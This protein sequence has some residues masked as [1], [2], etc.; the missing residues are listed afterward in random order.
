MLND[1][2]VATGAPEPP[3]GSVAAAEQAA[4][5]AAAH[6]AEWSHDMTVETHVYVPAAV[7]EGWMGVALRFV[8]QD[9]VIV[10]A[11]QLAP[12]PRVAVGEWRDGEQTLSVRN[13][14]MA[15]RTAVAADT[16]FQLRASAIGNEVRVHL[17]GD[18]VLVTAVAAA[19]SASSS[20]AGLYTNEA[21]YARFRGTDVFRGS[22]DVAAP[23]VQELQVAVLDTLADCLSCDSF[24]Y[25]A[26]ATPQVFSVSPPSGSAGTLVTVTGSSLLHPLPSLHVWIGDVECAVQGVSATEVTCTAGANVVGA[27]PVRVL[28]DGVGPAVVHAHHTS[29]SWHA[30]APEGSTHSV[31]TAP[32]YN[33][34]FTHTLTAVAAPTPLPAGSPMG[35]SLLTLTGEGF[36]SQPESNL[37]TVCGRRCHVSEAS[38]TQLTCRVPPLVDNLPTLASGT[39]EGR[40][41]VTALADGDFGTTIE[42]G[43]WVDGYGAELII[44]NEALVGMQWRGLHIP[45]GATILSAE[46]VLT[47]AQESCADGRQIVMAL[48]D[49]ATGPRPLSSQPHDL[50][51]RPQSDVSVTWQ[52]RL[53]AWPGDL[54]ISADISTLLQRAVN[55]SHWDAHR[56]L[57]LLVQQ[58]SGGTACIARSS[59]SAHVDAAP[60][61][62]VAYVAPATDPAA[63]AQHLPAAG[64]RICNVTVAVAPQG[65][66]S[67]AVRQRVWPSAMP[68]VCP[69]G[70]MALTLGTTPVAPSIPDLAQS[71][72]AGR[73]V[74]AD[75][76]TAWRA[77]APLTMPAVSPWSADLTSYGTS[78]HLDGRTLFLISAVE[79]AYEDAA[80]SADRISVLVSVAEGELGD[81]SDDERAQWVRVGDAH[82][83]AAHR[84][85]HWLRLDVGAA[86]YARHV[87]IELVHGAPLS[88]GGAVITTIDVQELRV[89]GCPAPHGAGW[90]E[91]L[92]EHGFMYDTSAAPTVTAITPARG[93]TGGGT[94]LTVAG[95]GFGSDASAVS[96]LVG[97][98]PCNVTAVAS[99]QVNCTTGSTLPVRGGFK[100]VQV[101]VDGVG[102]APNGMAVPQTVDAAVF[103]YID[104]WSDSRSW[105]GQPPPVGCGPW[106]TDKDCRDSIHI[107]AGQVLLL[108]MTPNRFFLIIVEGSLIFDPDHGVD[109]HAHYVLVRGGTFQVGTETQP[110]MHKATITL[111]GD[112]LSAE[113]PTFG[114]KVL[115]CYKCTLDLHGKPVLRTWTRLAATSEAGSTTLE[116]LEPVDWS[117]GSEIV[118][119]PTGWDRFETEVAVVA[120]VSNGGATVTLT[121][122]L[123]HRHLGVSRVF[124]GVSVPLRAE[125]GLLSHNI[126]VRGDALSNECIDIATPAKVSCKQ[127]GAQIFLHSPGDESLRARIEHVELVEVGQAF[128]LGRYAIHFHMIGVVS[129]SY[130]RASAVHNSHNRAVALHGVH[131]LKVTDV[132]THNIKGHAFFIEDGIETLNELEHNLAV[133]TLPSMSLLNTDQTPAAFWITNAFNAYR[134]NAAV[135]STNYG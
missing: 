103:W 71:G 8:D 81:Y 50:S 107:P 113:L 129:Q 86:V 87:R 117:V 3:A 80:A 47:A 100:T 46:V 89:Y 56:S 27:H 42:W 128:R 95:A 75:A 61:L 101:I 124:D 18:L 93:S 11:V 2:V 105:G 121:Q 55:G 51:S 132:V 98:V 34:T 66:A 94:A 115:A 76:N 43:G 92:V 127:L 123:L 90:H 25:N 40:I 35:G 68:A 126:V 78:V 118:V 39:P 116:L 14:T 17:N 99:G 83:T 63:M 85:S 16:W 9:N 24:V 112:S 1:N 91:V 77:P 31:D 62:K 53:W 79:V 59:R 58:A 114:Q 48:D 52:G 6:A 5:E 60:V 82:A 97:D 41:E 106:E 104:R 96:V 38:H 131:R 20:T 84:T 70:G 37:V 65:H 72:E 54:Q 7:A 57:V 15:S 88:S 133:L 69:N 23:L 4:V 30:G 21:T 67:S 135:G 134:R 10:A 73:S 13:D 33:A 12:S 45:R 74:D 110:Y 122:P 32:G 28:V 125:V 29:A 19:A 49:T 119:A 102:G 120:G 130:M 36:A 22:Q 109:L 111:Y 64:M 44:D 108:D 26:T